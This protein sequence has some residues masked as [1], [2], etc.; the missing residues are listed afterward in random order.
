MSIH[1]NYK[2]AVI[3]AKDRSTVVTGRSAGA[4]VRVI[5]NQMT[6]DYLAR[7]KSG[8]DKMELERFTLGSLRRAVFDGDTRTGSL[9]AGQVAGMVHSIRPLRAIFEELQT[10]S[11]ACLRALNQSR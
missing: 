8:A 7:E 11:E 9:M 4:P 6:K 5:K 10:Q 1:E 3:A 2:Q